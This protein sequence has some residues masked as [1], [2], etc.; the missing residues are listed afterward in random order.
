MK[1][2]IIHLVIATAMKFPQK[3]CEIISMINPINSK[4]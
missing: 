1:V 4:I 3:M 2:S